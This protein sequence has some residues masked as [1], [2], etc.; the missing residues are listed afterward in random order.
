MG[1]CMSALKLGVLWFILPLH[2]D[3]KPP[4]YKIPETQ[5]LGRFSSLG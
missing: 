1:S 5:A 2:F 3:I 4:P